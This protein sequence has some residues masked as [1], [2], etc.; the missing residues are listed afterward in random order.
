MRSC[1]TVAL[2]LSFASVAIARADT[3]GQCHLVNVT[4][5]PTDQLQIVA[6]VEMASGTFVD[7]I[8]I[9]NKVGLYGLGNRPGSFALNSGPPANDMWPYG[10]RV[11]TF[12]VWAHR[13]GLSWPEV[14]FQNADETDVSHPAGQSSAEMAP[15][16]C[17]PMDTADRG[18]DSGTCATPNAFTDKGVFS[19]TQTSLYP[20]RADLTYTTCGDTPPC[21]SPS[22]MV[23]KAMNPF[24]AVTQ[25]T[26]PG[27]MQTTIP[28]AIPPGLAAGAYVLFVEVAKEYDYN[29][30]YNTT[31]YPGLGSGIPFGSYGVPYQGQPSIVYRVPFMIGAT[32]D[33][34]ATQA[35]AGYGDA[36]GATGTLHQPDATITID[37]PSS[38]ASRFEPIPGT[39]DLVQ[40][41]ALPVTNN[42]PPSDIT[43]LGTT[44]VTAASAAV[45]FI[46]PGDDGGTGPKV[47]GYEVRVRANEPITT[48]NFDS[49]M[50]VTANIVPSPAGSPQ[51]LEID[52]LLPQTPYWVGIK[53]YDGCHNESNL[54]V[55]T[56]T[57]LAP[58]NGQVD[59]CFIATAAY[60]S[61]MANDVELLRTFRDRMLK[62]NAFGELFV[63]AYYTFGPPVAGVVGSSEIL[64]ATAREALAPV[65][66]SVRGI[67]R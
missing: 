38:G 39:S 5:V 13:H 61:L 15:P 4:F 26:P 11:T 28:W 35:Y 36:D 63:E 41:D 52:G 23:F 43:N 40:L 56:L 45:T 18:W 6:W 17:R 46:A 51:A 60:G 12:P 7:T 33:M 58:S 64:R 24:D 2:A 3:S 48:T 66:D 30:T 16:Y 62:S 9:T 53:A 14:D 31:T 57:T 32:E 1:P 65:I 10:R 21:D 22:V 47:T 50:P 19:T 42:I 27:G 34:E 8:Y 20:P 54:A 55:T 29:A 37:T 59:A 44:N 49:S 25:A 67:V